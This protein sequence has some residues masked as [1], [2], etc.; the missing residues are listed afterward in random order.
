LV[1]KKEVSRVQNLSLW[2]NLKVTLHACVT[3][4]TYWE[5]AHAQYEE[6]YGVLVS[7]KQFSDPKKMITYYDLRMQTEERF[8][9]FKHAW[10]INE[11]PSPHAALVESHVCFTLLTYSLLQLYLQRKDLRDKTHQML[12][13]LRRDER[14]G[15]DAVLVYS[16]DNFGIFDLDDYTFRVAGLKETPRQRLMTTMQSQKEARL[17]REQ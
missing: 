10:Y 12:S 9:Q 13:T 5:P 3:R 11:F 8:R 14:L 1:L 7:T 6:R 2:N 15:K 4:Y 16:D 17:K